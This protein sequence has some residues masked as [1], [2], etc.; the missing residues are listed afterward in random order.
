M[1]DFQTFEDVEEWLAPMGFEA[2]WDAMRTIG[3]YGPEDQAHCDRTLAQG[4]ADMETVMCVTKR[5]ALHAL[6]A[7][8]DL[9]FRC[10][11]STSL[12]LRI[13]E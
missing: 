8:F 12:D 9:P 10:E 7:Q 5:M 2:F 1:I 11:L 13:V 4:V 6:V 3:L